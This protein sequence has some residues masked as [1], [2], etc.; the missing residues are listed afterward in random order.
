MGVAK[1]IELIGE[2]TEGWEDAVRDAVMRA[3]DTVEGITGVEVL[4]LTANVSDGD[5]VEFK[6]NVKLAFGVRQ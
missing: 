1:I 5:V 4:N 3:S 6:A 2:S